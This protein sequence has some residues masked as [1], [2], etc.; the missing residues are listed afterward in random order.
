MW[1]IGESVVIIKG[2]ETDEIEVECVI[3]LTPEKEIVE[4]GWIG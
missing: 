3:G 1:L 4:E 2:I